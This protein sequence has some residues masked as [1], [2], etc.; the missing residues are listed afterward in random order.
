MKTKE[1]AENSGVKWS[2]SEVCCTVCC[3]YD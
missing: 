2:Y 1:Q 3:Y